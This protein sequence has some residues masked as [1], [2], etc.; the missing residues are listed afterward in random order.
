MASSIDKQYGDLYIFG[1]YP[2]NY[3]DLVFSSYSEEFTLEH[4]S[5]ESA[6][7]FM[8]VWDAQRDKMHELD[9]KAWR[10]EQLSE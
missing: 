6:E 5:R 4:I 2:D 8:R 3:V 9:E 7:N 10:Y 1:K